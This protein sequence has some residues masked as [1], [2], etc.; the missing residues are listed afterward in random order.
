[1]LNILW[2]FMILISLIASFFNGKVEETVN[3]AMNGAAD[4]V[5]LCLELLGVMCMWNGLI[6]IADKAGITEKISAALKPIFRLIFPNIKRGSPA[7]RK[8]VMNITAN[9]LGMGNA[10]TPSGLKAMEELNKVCKYKEMAIFTVLNTASF[11]IIPSAII[12]MRQTVGSAN[13]SEIILPVW[14]ASACSVTAAVLCAR[15]LCK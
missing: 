13:P 6:K 10:A 14:C 1:M 15:V 4:G 7:E 5:N 2:S 11:Q 12:A 3:G 8:M 9:L